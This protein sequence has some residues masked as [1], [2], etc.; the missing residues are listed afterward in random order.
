MAQITN[1]ARILEGVTPDQVPFDDLLEANEPVILRGLVSNWELVKA[2]KASPEKAMERLESHSTGKPVG[3]YIAPSE[4]NARFFYND[5]CTGFN[6]EHKRVDLGDILAQI[7]ANQGDPDRPYCYMNSLT[8]DEHFPGLREQ[9]DL[10]FNHPV[11][12]NKKPL[13]KIWIGTESI[14]AA[15]YDVPSNIACCVLGSRRFTLFPPEQI[16]NL[17]PGPMEPTP[18]GQVVTMVDF[19]NP[20]FERFPRARQALD[21]AVV[22]DL[23][24]GDAVFYPS[25]WWHQVEASSPFNIM[26]NF[27]W[28]TAPAYMGNPLDIVMHAILGLRDRSE[29]EKKAWREVFDYYVFGSPETPREH[30]PAAAHGPL[31]DVDDNRARRLRALVKNGLNR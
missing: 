24:P 27:W 30:L 7:R 15:H 10:Q 23:E 5:D 22:V 14:A 1:T 13:A 19:K 3:V 25:M 16:H 28:R 31:A 26:I 17:Y 6:Y 2:G 9:N 4:T 21:A 11:F 12:T 29:S 20:D 18:G 8:L